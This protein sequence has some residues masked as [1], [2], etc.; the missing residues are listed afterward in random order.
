MDDDYK[1]ILY[2]IQKEK[3]T[4]FVERN[5]DHNNI[6][7]R[8]LAAAGFSL[9]KIK[10]NYLFN[11]KSFVSDNAAFSAKEGKLIIGSPVMILKQVRYERY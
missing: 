11:L 3:G 9:Y 4:K 6:P 7:N 10:E 8:Q 2:I 1:I 5:N